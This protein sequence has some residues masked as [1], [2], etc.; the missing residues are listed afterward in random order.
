MPGN[1]NPQTA[2]EPRAMMA[3]CL[4]LP[5]RR[6]SLRYLC[7][8]GLAA[9]GLG[10]L[11]AQLKAPANLYDE[12]LTLLNT[13]RILRGQ[14]PYRDYWTLYA[15]GYFYLLAG[16][17]KLAAPNLLTARL[18]D[19]CLRFVLTLEVYLLARRMTRAKQHGWWVALIPW[20]FVTLW[21]SAIRFY[22]Y[23]AFPAT[24]LILASLLAL[25]RYVENRSPRWLALTGI[26]IG[27]TA[28]LRLDF[29]GYAAAGIALAVAIFDLR[30]PAGD[31]SWEKRG[32]RLLKAEAILGGGALVIA[33]P[34]YAYLAAASGPATLWSD[35]IVFPATTFRAVRH[36]PVPSLVPDIG[37]MSGEQWEDWV[38]LYLPLGVYA[39]ALVASRE[40]FLGRRGAQRR[41]EQAP[42]CENL[43]PPRSG[44]SASPTLS[45]L[46]IA[47]T[48][49]GLGLVVKATS[50]YHELHALPTA[51]LAVIAATALAG[52]IPARLWRSLPFCLGLTGLAFM[53][54]LGPYVLHFTLMFDQ[55]ARYQMAGCYASLERAGCVPMAQ[56]QALAVEYIQARTQPGEYV[57]VGNARHDLI[58]A[59][60]L[61]FNFV[62][63]RPS[64]T[65]YTELHP[66]L[67][68]TL[69]VQ[70]AIARDLTIKQ[71][72]W[73]VTF[74][75]WEPRE[76]NASSVSS[77]VTYLDDFIRENY[78]SVTRLGHYRI[79]QKRQ[80]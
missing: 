70:Q 30:Q 11:C 77:G 35:L 51:I 5:A 60:D 74:K 15:P 71:V 48:I 7:L 14:L 50:R 38:R 28:I 64:P 41:A 26:T 24:A 47:L 22:S 65:R 67:A 10:L 19:T 75:G 9:G 54:T 62:A 13:D 66:G 2:I 80:P 79:W 55:T 69:P 32:A 46:L 68:T 27:L 25:S 49:T 57:F 45:S 34:L 8:A 40:L 59:N 29:G 36:L 37:R 4:A 56:D 18:L 53:L 76:P 6:V 31:V 23:P 73:V 61:L 78:A 44:T 21:L 52:N 3:R 16:L 1:L 42:S 43:R 72:Q 39:A 20:A 63:D 12:G 33:L 58:F 17:F